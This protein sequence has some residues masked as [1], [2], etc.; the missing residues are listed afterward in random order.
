MAGR[1]CCGA[2]LRALALAIATLLLAQLGAEA[3]RLAGQDGE[4][5]AESNTTSASPVS[6]R[7]QHPQAN[8]AW[9]VSPFMIVGS[10]T[11]KSQFF[12]APGR[13][14]LASGFEV[15]VG[16]GGVNGIA[17]TFTEGSFTEGSTAVIGTRVGSHSAISLAKGERITAMSLW[18]N[19]QPKP[20]WAFG[21]MRIVTDAGQTFEAGVPAGHRG[22]EYS[23]DVGSGLV[24]GVEGYHGDAVNAFGA[25]FLKP[26]A[27]A[28]MEVTGYP[29]L[30]GLSP[31]GGKEQAV[32]AYVT[33]SNYG[34]QP[35]HV[36]MSGSPTVTAKHWWEFD[37]PKVLG[38]DVA[39]RAG[40]PRV[41][42]S[43]GVPS[44]WTVTEAEDWSS[45]DAREDVERVYDL[46]LTVNPHSSV[47][48]KATLAEIDLDIEFTARMAVT[49]DDGAIWGYHTTGHYVGLAYAVTVT[50]G[51]ETSL[52]DGG[53]QEEAVEEVAD[54]RAVDPPVEEDRRQPVKVAD[55]AVW[56]W[57]SNG[58]VAGEIAVT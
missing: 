27:S 55:P 49:V 43:D 24:V 56:E 37:A 11:G 14:A 22:E 36:R 12:W 1:A 10:S 53:E 44:N 17:V 2:Y 20:R 45:Q 58:N 30:Q 54:D 29:T 15:W 41:V 26:V 57:S 3:R 13:G 23:L 21:A 40:V 5:A 47:D 32:L 38:V 6:G 7:L 48:A 25:C 9:T 19:G 4:G 42:E 35:Q 39:I 46:P 28:A 34:D 33:Y 50:L 31:A 16:A 51:D 18:D 52:K 8:V